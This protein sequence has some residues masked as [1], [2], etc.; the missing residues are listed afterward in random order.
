[1]ERPNTIYCE[2]ARDAKRVCAYGN[3][4]LSHPID[5]SEPS[6]LALLY[7]VQGR[8]ALYHERYENIAVMFASIPNYKEFYDETDNSKSKINTFLRFQ[9][10][11]KPKFSCIEKIKTIGSTYMAASG[12]Q[13]G[14]DSSKD[15]PRTE[16]NVIILLEFGIALMSVLDQINKESFQRFRLRVAITSSHIGIDNMVKQTISEEKIENKLQSCYHPN[17]FS[18]RPNIAFRV[19][20]LHFLCIPDIHSINHGPV[21]AGVVGAQKPQYDIWGNTVNVA[22][23]M[24]SCGNVGKVQVTESTAIILKN[25]G[26]ECTSRGLTFVK[27]KGNLN[28]YF[29]KTPYDNFE[30]RINQRQLNL[31]NCIT[32]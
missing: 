5:V 13:P 10:L 26:Y 29:V 7:L 19:L 25:A 4:I 16:H 24:D 20:S 15:R 27:G 32:F 6:Q 30:K 18:N 17:H 2:F 23:R 21:I 31:F 3:S 9:L 11:S 8:F 1:M 12:L 22:S 28:T 14:K